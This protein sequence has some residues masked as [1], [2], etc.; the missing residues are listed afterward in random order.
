MK[1]AIK[2]NNQINKEYKTG[3]EEITNDIYKQ[4]KVLAQNIVQKT[5]E[6]IFNIQI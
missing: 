5:R 6:R 2:D 3:V 4:Q 1:E